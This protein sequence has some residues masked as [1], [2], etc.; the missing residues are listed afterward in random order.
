MIKKTKQLMWASCFIISAVI[1]TVFIN[2]AKTEIIPGSKAPLFT[3][4]DIN[5]KTYD[6]GATKQSLMTVLYFFDASSRPS[7]EGLISLNNLIKRYGKADFTVWAITRSPKKD[8][9]KF[10]EKLKPAFPVMLDTDSISKKYNAT[11]I[12]PT[13]CV[14]G[15][16]LKVIDFLQGGGKTVEVMLI[17]LAER[18]LNRRDTSLAQI[19]TNE[20]LKKDPKNTKAQIVKGY[21]AL[22][23]GKLNEAEKTFRSVAKKKD[24]DGLLG[25][26]GLAAVYALKGDNKK[27]LTLASEVEKKAPQRSYAHVIK[28][29]ILYRQGKIR[30]A[31]VEFEKGAKAPS[32]EI[33]QKADALNKF[34]RFYASKGKYIQA[35]ALYDKA[36]KIDPY[37]VEATSNK[38]VT[39]E[40]QGQWDKALSAY[41]KALGIDKSDAFSAA[42]A[43]N[44]Q[45]MVEI[46][47]NAERKKRMDRLIQN[48]AERFRKQKAVHTK[49]KED[50]WTS[51]PMVMTFI[52]F[53]EQGGLSNRDGLSTVIA[54]QIGEQLNQSGRVH[55]VERVLMERLLD[56][57]NLGSSDLADKETALQL[58]RIL[59]AKLI[60]TGSIFYFPGKTMLNMRLIDTET[61]FINKVITRHL[62][63][64]TSLDNEMFRLSREILQTIMEKYPLRGFI[65]QAD[66][67]RIMLNIGSRQGVVKGTKFNV[68]KDRPPIH[69]R[70][71]LL[72]S[73]PEVV[74]CI[75]V[76]KVEPDLCF[77]KIIKQKRSFKRDDKVQELVETG[78]VSNI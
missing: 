42:L 38:G 62:D 55:V 26:E 27:A 18:N 23:T 57:L 73:A 56:E 11:Q 67:N 14:L 31:G 68:L 63:T 51:S 5:G 19:I 21:A 17:R 2:K 12:L 46:Q 44:A 29:D 32:A 65:V 8:T 66:N 41:K 25:K 71:K 24:K 4:A 40:K 49:E 16:D 15:P 20:V 6:L 13:V 77:A 58:G 43:K 64:R 52:D 28:G 39:F 35:R 59:A 78:S 69:Y 60:S 33:F 61:T 53:T 50:T 37:M 9:I 74:G 10:V 72:K 48:L 1:L 75:E 76:F 45:K 70:G 34:G 54:A 7:Q 3:I 36:V 22:K 47:N 30:Q